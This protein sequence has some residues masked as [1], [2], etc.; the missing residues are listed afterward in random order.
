MFVYD[1]LYLKEF[2]EQRLNVLASTQPTPPPI[3]T[4]EALDTILSTPSYM[5]PNEI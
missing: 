3:Y 1:P 4:I 5:A 2:K